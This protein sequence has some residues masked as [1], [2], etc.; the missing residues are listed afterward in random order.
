MKESI[1]LGFILIM[2]VF[3]GAFVLADDDDETVDIEDVELEGIDSDE[4][5]EA[6]ESGCAYGH[7]KRIGFATVRTGNGWMNNEEDGK[8]INVFWAS[9]KVA[10]T[11][12]EEIVSEIRAGGSL[13]I[14]GGEHYR[15]V[16]ILEEDSSEDDSSISFHVLDSMVGL[17]NQRGTG[18]PEETCLSEELTEEDYIG[19]L[20][21]NKKNEYENLIIWDGK[22]VLTEGNLTGSWDVNFASNVNTLKPKRAMEVANLEQGKKVGFWGKFKFW[23][24]NKAD[25]QN[26]EE[27]N[28][29]EIV[30]NTKVKRAEVLEAVKERKANHRNNQEE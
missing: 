29:S 19:T 17:E 12:E 4:I 13:K 26:N 1:I 10:N 15:L 2:S 8:L 14:V 16:R 20:T 22:L 28:A 25:I 24:R 23:K 9:Q 5:E 18:E 7:N 21:L 6:I 30:A 11:D 3:A 27:F